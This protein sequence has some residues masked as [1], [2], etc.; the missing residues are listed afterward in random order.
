MSDMDV[1]HQFRNIVLAGIV[2]LAAG[3]LVPAGASDQASAARQLAQTLDGARGFLDR[4]VAAIDPADYEVSARA[5]ALGSDTARIFAFV[6]DDI[7]FE[8]YR[9][10]LRG[11]TG[12]MLSAAGN[13]ADKALLLA[14]LLQAS[15]QRTRFAFGTLKPEDATGLVEACAAELPGAPDASLEFPY[16]LEAPWVM[17]ER[18]DA[19]AALKARVVGRHER[20]LAALDS[21]LKDR[22]RTGGNRAALPVESAAALV[23]EHVWVQLARPDGTYQD[24]DPSFWDAEPGQ[25]FAEV[26]KTAPKLPE[27]WRHR[28]EFRAGSEWY[29]D[30]KV[31]DK[32]AWRKSFLASDVATAPIVVEALHP[33]R[34]G[35]PAGLLSVSTRGPASRDFSLRFGGWRVAS[36]PLELVQPS[37]SSRAASSPLVRGLSALDKIRGDARPPPPPR[38]GGGGPPPASTCRSKLCSRTFATEL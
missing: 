23:R 2:L 37:A 26:A 1:H 27:G 9:G 19:A 7:R 21:A 38:G 24:L 6:R 8:L 5:R 16:E 32:Q 30:G 3:G 13:A 34:P 10:A 15:G 25:R 17:K 33:P 29:T 28:V 12:C 31:V 18:A 36:T 14:E 22:A 11:G 20:L 4:F 35:G